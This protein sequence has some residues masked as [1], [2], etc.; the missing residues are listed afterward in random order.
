VNTNV[1]RRIK[2]A[3]VLAGGGLTGAVYEIGALRA[4][5]DLLVDY[6][7][8]DFEVYVGTSAGALV[9][10]M[11]ANGLS[12]ETMLQAIAGNHPDIPPIE[13]QD[14]FHFSHGDMILWGLR[15]PQSLLGALSHY[16]RNLDDM[17]LFDF[18][19]SLSEALPPG[20]YDNLA[21]ER[22]VRRVLDRP[23]LTNDFRELPRDLHIIATDHDSG[24]RTVFGR[25]ERGHVSI[26]TA[27]AASTAVPMVYKPVRVGD[28]EY[29]DGGLRGTAS[30]DLAIEHGARLIVCINP[31]VPFDNSKHADIPALGV[32]GSYLSE[33]GLAAIASQ[34]GRVASHAGLHY[35]IKQLRK[36]HPHVEIILI[37]PGRHDYRMFFSNTMR[38]S[39]WLTVA[40]HGF[41]TVSPG[42]AEDF[43]HYRQLLERYRV[44]ITRT[45]VEEEIATIRASSYDP[46]VTRRLF[47]SR[48]PGQK[49]SQ[50]KGPL[51]GL[52]HTLERIPNQIVVSFDYVAGHSER[53][54]AQSKNARH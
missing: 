14:I 27:V 2:S 43:E 22:Y 53:S 48:S 9:A 24:E 32:V 45:L 25:H 42:L 31:L 54:K 19:W 18:M 16:L 39:A 34:V 44:R 21:V 4:I 37:E 7:V 49:R 29:V 26:S 5:N 40:R 28:H 50:P 33:K 13:R 3:L 35:H 36:M 52:A 11:L 10:A 6:A 15:L 8:N 17:T 30:L 38:Y 51:K 41:E 23:G 46:A 1:T 20:L 12:P 47:E